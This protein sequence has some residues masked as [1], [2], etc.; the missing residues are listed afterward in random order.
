VA[1]ALSI[2]REH[3]VRTTGGSFHELS[4]DTLCLHGDTPGA[5]DIGCAVRAAL[6][7][8]E[9]VVRPLRGWKPEGPDPG[10]PRMP[11]R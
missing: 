11:S 3:R 5:R 4:V 7:K 6:L 2:V 1:Q 8:A 9:V 10:P